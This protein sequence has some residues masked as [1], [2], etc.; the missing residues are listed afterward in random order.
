M[1]SKPMIET[2]SCRTGRHRPRRVSIG[3][4]GGTPTTTCRDCGCT[5]TRTLATRQWV[6]SGQLA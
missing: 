6:Y 3:A 5:L 2:S 1:A 4:A